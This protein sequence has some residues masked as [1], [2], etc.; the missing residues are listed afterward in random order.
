MCPGK[1]ATIAVYVEAHESRG[2]VSISTCTRSCQIQVVQEE[3]SSELLSANVSIKTWNS[4]KGETAAPK[5]LDS[6]A[7]QHL[8]EPA[9]DCVVTNKVKVDKDP[10]NRHLTVEPDTVHSVPIHVDLNVAETEQ[11]SNTDE[12]EFFVDFIESLEADSFI[13]NDDEV[14]LKK[15]R[16]V[17][18]VDLH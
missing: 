15:K 4:G 18:T 6:V 17:L 1:T 9:C 13:D 8:E 11:F 10:A 16:F 3:E 5:E 7:P 2:K 14:L 12:Q